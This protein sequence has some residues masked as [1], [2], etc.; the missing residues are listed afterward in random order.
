MKT[1]IRETILSRS[2]RRRL[3]EF[4]RRRRRVERE[5]GFWVGLRYGSASIGDKDNGEFERLQRCETAGDFVRFYLD[6]AMPV[7][8][9]PEMSAR[10]RWNWL[11][12]AASPY[13]SDGTAKPEFEH[14]SWFGAFRDLL[15]ADP[16]VLVGCLP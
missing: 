4:E 3:Q 2:G 9:W 11:R 6:T 1:H 7:K 14:E 15:D 16:G 13:Y 12:G 10:D 5:L 8:A